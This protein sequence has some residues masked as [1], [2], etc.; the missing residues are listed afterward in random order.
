MGHSHA[1][2]DNTG[3]IAGIAA[4]SAGIG[5]LMAMLVTPRTGQ[6]VR[7]GIKRRA[8]H[9]MD[10]AS[11]TFSHAKEAGDDL[12]DTAE[13]KAKDMAESGR[14]SAKRAAD[15]AKEKKDASK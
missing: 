3:M 12:M 4:L 13:D 7:G 14:Q 9:A 10:R 6:Q 1:M 5:A 11:D 8:H 2:R 15:T